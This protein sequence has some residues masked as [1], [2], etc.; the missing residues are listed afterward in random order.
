MKEVQR[1]SMLFQRKILGILCML[2][3]PS[4]ILFGLIGKSTNLPYWYKSISSTYYANDKIIMIGLLY[5]IA[6]FFSAYKGYDWRDRTC[7][8]IQAVSSF[9][10]VAFPCDTPGIPQNVGLFLAPVS[11]SNIIHCISASVLFITFAFNVLFLFRL[12]GPEPTE[13]KLLRNKIY[14]VCGIIISIFMILEGI[15]SVTSLFDFIPSWFPITW[16]N[17]FVMLEAFGFAYFVK[18]EAIDKLND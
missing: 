10:I 9:L 4:S 16:F 18:S 13:K 5:A 6:I 2:L 1:E 17:E 11:V 15:Y 7:S 12:C 14:L 8:L 3:A